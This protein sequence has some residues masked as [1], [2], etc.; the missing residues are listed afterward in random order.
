MIKNILVL[1]L[2]L[3]P[4][5]S[6]SQS[7][8]DIANQA[9]SMGIS[10][11]SDVLNELARRGMTEADA[12]RMA[13]V[14]GI[15]YDEYMSTYILNTISSEIVSPV[16]SELTIDT[17]IVPLEVQEELIEEKTEDIIESMSYFGY[18]IFLNNPFANKEYLVGNIDEGYILAL[19]E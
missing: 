18:D 13:A 17:M 2:I 8:E 10:T 1:L 5:I 4:Y 12:R 14:Y 6:N 3:I 9:S 16:V 11:Q 15:S 7:L 19:L